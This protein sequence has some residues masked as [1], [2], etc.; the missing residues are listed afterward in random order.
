MKNVSSVAFS[1]PAVP[2]LLKTR[3]RPLTPTR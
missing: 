1:V 2:A 3:I